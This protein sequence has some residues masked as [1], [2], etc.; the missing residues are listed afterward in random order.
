V[1]FARTEY[2]E[3]LMGGGVVSLHP[4]I[5]LRNY[6]LNAVLESIGQD[7]RRHQCVQSGS[8]AH[9]LFSDVF[10]GSH[11]EGKAGGT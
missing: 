2:N 7:C 1:S 3:R 5:S 11:T 10:R 9:P 8:C 6:C 4:H